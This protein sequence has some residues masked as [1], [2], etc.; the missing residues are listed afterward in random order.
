[1]RQTGREIAR[2]LPLEDSVVYTRVA[3]STTLPRVAQFVFTAFGVQV[4]SSSVDMIESGLIQSLALVTLIAEIQDEFQ[5]NLP[6]M[7]SI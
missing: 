1:M 4:P 5:I 2:P 6:L 7:T 3:A